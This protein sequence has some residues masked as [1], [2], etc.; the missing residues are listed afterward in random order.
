MFVRGTPPLGLGL[1]LGLM[2]ACV[3]PA[4]GEEGVAWTEAGD[5]LPSWA[6]ENTLQLQLSTDSTNYAVI[7]LTEKLASGS[8]GPSGSVSR[9]T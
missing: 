1:G 7:P 8:P 2:L 5:S 4:A 9:V 6:S 3:G